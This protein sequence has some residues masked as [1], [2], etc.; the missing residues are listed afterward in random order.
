[1]KNKVTV[2]GLGLMGSALVRT[3]SAANLKVTVWNR[4]PH[5]AQLFEPG[6]V[7]IA[8]TIAE[9]VQASDIIVVC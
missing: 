2:I 7:T 9:A 8:D 5:K 3:L 4:S 6:T 1:M